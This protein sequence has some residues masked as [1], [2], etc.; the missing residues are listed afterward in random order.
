M[1]KP[2]ISAPFKAFVSAVLNPEMLSRIV[3][4]IQSNMHSAE[5]STERDADLSLIETAVYE[6]YTF[7]SAALGAWI[8][9]RR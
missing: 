3:Q 6:P 1:K 5:H 8:G 9:R 2:R 7:G 4:A